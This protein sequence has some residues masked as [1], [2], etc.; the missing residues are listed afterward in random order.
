MTT[1]APARLI[2]TLLFVASALSARA[3]LIDP[4]DFTT[5]GFVG[6]ATQGPLD[7]P[8][9]V[10][11]YPEF[12]A[13]FGSST[14]GLAN[15]YL[16]PSVAGYFANGGVGLVVVRV[17]SVDAAT[18]IGVDGGAPGLRTGLQA[19]LD[20][21]EVS[22]I[23]IPGV[24][25]PAVQTAMIAHCENAGDRMAIL[26]PASSNDVNAI[27]VQ[28]S[29][30]V[31]DNGFAALY[32][33]WVQASPTGTS[34]LL[35]P[36]GFV[37]GAYSAKEPPDAPVG[38]IATASGVAYAVSAAEQDLLNPQGINAIRDLSGIRIWGAR[39]L[40]SSPD[41]IYVS[42]RRLGLFIEESIAQST[43]WCLFEPNDFN[44]WAVLE[45]DMDDFLYELWVQ[46]W[47]QGATPGEAY[48][49]NCG[50]GTT[51][52]QTD[53]DEG[54]TILQMGFAPVRPVEFN[55]LSVVHQRPDLTAAQDMA[56]TQLKLL[57]PTP[58]PFNPT[59]TLRFELTEDAR[60]DL[61]VFDA[62]GRLVRTILADQWLSA[63]EYRRR[64]DGKDNGGRSVGSGV[65]LARI[66]GDGMVQLRRMVLVR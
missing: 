16:A 55:V 28:R 30:L 15:P 22:F 45:Q 21:D 29:G 41:W 20:V 11:N 36:S 40:A 14:A 53:I 23:A 9:L 54:R 58:N 43:Q 8:V 6:M 38:V 66:Q 52:T 51:M 65:Y 18:V 25:T 17:A 42:S 48:F 1:K 24:A 19:L 59:T 56:A 31:T 60:V 63:G 61:R 62:A 7:Q 10:N 35:P 44:L 47:L 46:A 13:I 49:A 39:T 27:Q 12:T 34:L 26:D 33:P 5:A 4:V 64:W 50:L 2:L 3:A 57:P 37:A 32:F